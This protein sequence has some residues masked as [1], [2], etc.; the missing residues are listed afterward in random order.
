MA[1]S[2]GNVADSTGLAELAHREYQAG[3]FEAAERHCMQLWRQEPDNTGVLLLLSS[4]HFQCRRLDRTPFWQ[5]PIQTWATCTRKEDSCRKRLS[6]TGMHCVSSQISSMVTLTWQPHWWQQVTWK[7][8]SK[9]TSLLFSTILI[10]TV[11]AVTW[12]TCL[13]PWVA[14]KKPR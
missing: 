12:G 3:D 10:C 9:L 1:S 7:G 2:V 6:I 14:W 5:K 4:I 11:F 13:K 8:Q